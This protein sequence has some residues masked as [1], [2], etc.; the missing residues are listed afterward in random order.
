MSAIAARLLTT[1]EDYREAVAL[2][3]KIWGFADLELLPVRLFVVAGKIGGQSFGAFDGSRMV[4]FTLAI[5]GCKRGEKGGVYL[6]S[7]MLGVLPEYRNRGIGRMLKLA[8]REKAL[9]DGLDLME[10]TFDPLELKN[11]FLNIERLGAV[12]RRYVLNQYGTTSSHL[13]GSLPTD[14]CIAEWWLASR[15]VRERLE[16]AEPAGRT[17]PEARIEV[18]ADIAALRREQPRKARE[19]QTAISEKFLEC[20]SRGLA[21]IGFERAERCGT[22]LLGTWESD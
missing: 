12:V 3:Q 22:Y 1:V 20:F 8:Q 11:A 15:R 9:A 6:H 16:G 17:Q 2:Q 21:V 14:R 18:P 7:H 13:H 4:A 5:P 10:W 19:I